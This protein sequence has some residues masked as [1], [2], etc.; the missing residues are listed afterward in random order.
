M[1]VVEA[2]LR[3]GTFI[4]VDFALEY[5]KGGVDPMSYEKLR[6]RE[7]VQRSNILSALMFEDVS[8]SLN[9]GLSQTLNNIPPT[10]TP[11]EKI[12]KA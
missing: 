2:G 1:I 6:Y 4:T 10:D 11:L 12:I 5:G 9:I 8:A 7:V 3:S